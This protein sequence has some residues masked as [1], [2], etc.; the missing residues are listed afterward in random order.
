KYCLQFTGLSIGTNMKFKMPIW[1]HSATNKMRYKQACR[2]EAAK[3]LRLNRRVR[4]VYDTLT[5]AN[6]R[7]VNC[8]CPLCYQDPTELG[9]E[10]PGECIETAKM[11]IDSI[12]SKWNPMMV[13]LDLC[14]ELEWN[15]KPLEIDQVMVFD[16]NFTLSKVSGS[17]LLRNH[18]MRSQ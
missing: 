1:K 6:R 9:C 10:Y 5:I 7:T 2:R 12:L 11:L 8:G 3:C 17:L 14:E 4:T 13:N 16:P 15:K 18:S